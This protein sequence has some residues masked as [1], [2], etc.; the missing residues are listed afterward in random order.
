MFREQIPS[1]V[2]HL[3]NHYDLKICIAC[4]V[5][6]RPGECVVIACVLFKVA[7]SVRRECEE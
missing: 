5:T 7:H 3:M 4:P 6:E 2:L 1:V